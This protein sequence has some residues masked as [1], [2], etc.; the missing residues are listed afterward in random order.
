MNKSVESL[1]IKILIADGH[2]IYS[3]GLNVAIG[4]QADMFVVAQ[5]GCFS[6]MLAHFRLHTPD[7]TLLDHALP[8]LNGIDAIL[9]ITDAFPTARIVTLTNF[10]GDLIVQ[11]TIRAGAAGCLTK[12]VHQSELLEMIRLVHSGQKRVSS[13]IAE[14]LAE[15]F[16]QE[17]LSPRE[18]DVLKL[19]RD[20]RQNKEIAYRLSIAESTVNFHIKNLV[21]KLRASGRA[22]A[23]AIALSRGLLAV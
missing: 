5:V 2:P 7:V 20:G 11:R 14:R 3:D 13:E 18:I 10:E 19:I 16:C 1:P 4:S 6:E 15:G 23:V 17:S 22:H 8:G 21:D 9:S 12:S